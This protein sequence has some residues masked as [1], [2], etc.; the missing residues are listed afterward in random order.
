[1]GSWKIWIESHRQVLQGHDASRKNSGNK[2]SIERIPWAPKFEERTQDETLKQEG[3]ARR[4]AGDLAKDV[5][6]LKKGENRCFLISC[7]SLV[8]WAT[9]STKPEEREFVIDSG[10]AMH[11]LSKKDLRSGE[12]ET[13][14]RSRTP[15]TVV[16]ANGAVQTNEEAQ[17]YV[18]DLHISVAVQLLEDSPAVLS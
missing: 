5:Q 14:K 18:H 3:C 4:E 16:T 11:I 7:R 17:V 1:M 8:M 13:L 12:L 2:G 9:S 15:I 10:A 6:K